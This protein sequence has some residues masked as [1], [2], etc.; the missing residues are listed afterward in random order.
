MKIKVPES[1][2][3]YYNNDAVREAVDNLLGKKIK[4]T[5]QSLDLLENSYKAKL[6]AEKTKLD[7][8]L[9]LKEIY[10]KTVIASID[11]KKP[12]FK[13]CSKWDEKEEYLD[14]DK[15]WDR[16]IFGVLFAVSNKF[17]DMYIMKDENEPSFYIGFCC[18]EFENNKTITEDDFEYKKLEEFGN[19]EFETEEDPKEKDYETLRSKSVKI[20]GGTMDITHLKEATDDFIEKYC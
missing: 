17:V 11:E 13:E 9:F 3:L 10:E 5:D 18:G 14:I 16:A 2:Q 8:W 4:I 7:Y 1:L 12:Q 15:I 19:Y 6:A 20:N